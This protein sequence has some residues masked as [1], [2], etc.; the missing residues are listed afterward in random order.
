MYQSQ[1]EE[2]FRQQLRKALEITPEQIN[3]RWKL[4]P[5]QGFTPAKAIAHLVESDRMCPEFGILSRCNVLEDLEMLTENDGLMAIAKELQKLN[6]ALAPTSK[7]LGF[8][9]APKTQ[10]HV[11]CNRKH[12]GVW[13]TLNA[14]SQPEIIEYQALTGIIRRIEF[15]NVERR[16]EETSKLHCYVE[17]EK[18][19]VLES[20]SKAHF[21][22]GL[23]SAIT[24]IPWDELMNP[25]TIHPQAAT[26]SAEVLFCNVY[27][28]DKH[29]FAPY[30][31]KT[32]WASLARTARN[33]VRLANGESITEPR[34]V[35]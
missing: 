33:N 15:K 23:L 4:F 12:G 8:G 31:D 18:L 3:F 35:A 30:D 24:S 28:G 34:A 1:W 5:K 19:Y 32:D 27:Q 7:T 20:G 17:A 11:F 10:T 25:I 2:K 22:K 26:E 21:T 29:V 6:E 16:K 13:Y 14:Q 9:D